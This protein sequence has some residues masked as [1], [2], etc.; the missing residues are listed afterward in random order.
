MTPRQI[1]DIGV[2]RLGLPVPT[3][4]L[5]TIQAI[6][7]ALADVR[8]ADVFEAALLDWIA[9]RELESEC[10]EGLSAL[11]LARPGADLIARARRAIGRPSIASDH[12]LSLATDNPTVLP[13][14]VGCHAGP[15]PKLLDVGNE[16]KSLRAHTFIPPV[17]IH[18]LE[19]L[20]E[21]S[22]QAFVRQWAFE[23]SLLR[24]RV[25]STADGHFG[26][27]MGRERHNG[28]QFVARQ[29][30]LARSAYLRTLACAV[31][32]WG[33]PQR[34]ADHYAMQALPAEPLFLKLAPG[35]DPAWASGLH[36]HLPEATKD[37]E[38][39]VRG[40]L[41]QIEAAGERRVVHLSMAVSDSALC[42]VEL[43]VFAVASAQVVSDPQHVLSFYDHILGKMTPVRDGLR[44]FVCPQL[45]LRGTQR[46]GFVPAV[47]PLIGPTVGYLQ[48]DFVGRIPYVPLSTASLPQLELVPAVGG[49]QLTSRAAPV[50]E[51]ACWYWNWQPSHPQGW[52][53]PIACCSTLNRDA[54][55]VFAA[56]IGGRVQQV[57]KVV[58]WTRQTEYGD[59]SSTEELGVIDS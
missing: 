40:A 6:S 30:L 51:F 28:G 57:W 23:F 59:W 9:A 52:P 11:V 22:G 19:D 35:P 26:Y 58:R 50:G 10:L 5:V 44:A 37:A 2:A 27:F 12:L 25:S 17:F 31:E 46:L 3:G 53:S 43:V 20:E 34:F 33:M 36:R 16:L 4:K 29:G 14:W 24:Q 54:A 15:A 41:Q 55:E 8:T 42:H 7:Q 32:H 47:I 38:A 56:D 39:L 1:A 49:A 18:T 48:S 45:P 21:Q 13:S